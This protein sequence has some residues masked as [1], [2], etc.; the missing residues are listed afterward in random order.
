MHN[1]VIVTPHTEKPGM[2]QLHFSLFPINA[3]QLCHR[4]VVERYGNPKPELEKKLIF[5]AQ[6]YKFG[7]LESSQ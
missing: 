1:P 3:A 4:L 6:S 2:V 5:S 7:S